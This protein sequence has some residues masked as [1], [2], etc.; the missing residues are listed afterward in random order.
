MSHELG[1]L[2]SDLLPGG[3]H[4]SAVIRRGQSLRITDLEGGANLA[5][6]AYAASEKTERLNLPDTLKCQHSARLTA[7][8]CLYSDMGHVLLCITQDSL[9]WHDAIGGVSNAAEVLQQFGAGDF[10][11][12]RNSFHRN[13]QDNLLV[14]IGK[15]GLTRRD[16]A[17]NVNFFSKVVADDE[18]RFAFA[19]PHSKAGDFVE[20]VAPMDTLVVLT[21]IQHPLDPVTAY[22][23]KPVRLSVSR[24]DDL[25][26]AIA[27]CRA[28]RPENARGLALTERL[29]L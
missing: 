29:A 18:G 21:A 15:W 1:E 17:M 7:G 5:L 13:G 22:A 11:D 16:L 4:W 24:V 23:P 27:A 3:A 28:S 9:G 25:D 6:L 26:A 10:Q 12:L 20:L 8:H 2:Y 19:T 14:E